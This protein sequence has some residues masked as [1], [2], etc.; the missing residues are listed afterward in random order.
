M[1]RL[2]LLAACAAVAAAGT[3]M[4]PE[5]CKLDTDCGEGLFCRTALAASG[6]VCDP[7]L[8][9]TCVKLSGRGETCGGD[10]EA[11]E[12]FRNRCK[13]PLACRKTSLEAKALGTCVKQCTV[14]LEGDKTMTV[15]EGWTGPALKQWCHKRYCDGSGDKEVGEVKEVP[16]DEVCPQSLKEGLRCCVGQSENGKNQECCGA[17]GQWVTPVEGKVTCAGVEATVGRDLA[18]PFSRTCTGVC[19]RENA[20]AVDDGWKGP[21]TEEG[22]WCN[23]CVCA[24][25]ALTCTKR[26]CPVLKCCPQAKKIPGVEDQV[27]CGATGEWVAVDANKNVACSGV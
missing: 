26:E 24:R 6:S 14:E 5:T 7:S 27:C 11:Y 25:G 13:E 22:K 10:G 4:T 1:M 17:N 16:S 20:D 2:P 15:Y 3:T 9:K 19:K 12:C 18:A 8:P 21:S 23:T